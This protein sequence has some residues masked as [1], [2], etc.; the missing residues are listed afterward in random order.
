MSGSASQGVTG[1]SIPHPVGSMGV[2]GA[3]VIALG[4]ILSYWNIAMPNQVSAAFT[5]LFGAAFH[6]AS[7]WNVQRIIR[8]NV[9]SSSPST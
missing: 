7:S 8:Q 6:S 2:A 4:W 5:V 9:A 3:A 1:P